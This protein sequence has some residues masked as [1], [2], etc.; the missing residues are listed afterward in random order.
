MKIKGLVMNKPQTLGAGLKRVKKQ[1]GVTGENLSNQLGERRYNCY[2]G[3][4]VR[5]INS[6]YT[7]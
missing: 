7:S 1:F 2:G 4:H 3:N 6:W 5:Y